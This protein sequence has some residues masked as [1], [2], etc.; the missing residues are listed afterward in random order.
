[1]ISTERRHHSHKQKVSLL[2]VHINVLLPSHM[3]IRKQ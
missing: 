1:M 2:I 3:I